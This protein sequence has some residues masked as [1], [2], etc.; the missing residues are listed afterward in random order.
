M[1][2]KISKDEVE[3]FEYFTTRLCEYSFARAKDGRYF[4]P[5]TL[6]KL[7]ENAVICMIRGDYIRSGRPLRGKE[8][9]AIIKIF[10]AQAKQL[11]NEMFENP[12][13]KDQIIEADIEE[14]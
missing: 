1:K 14:D 4:D 8:L 7:T 5:I 6:Q 2:K 11:V 3:A 12:E 10:L 13:F 9:V